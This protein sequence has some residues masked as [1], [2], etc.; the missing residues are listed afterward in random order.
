MSEG[1]EMSQRCCRTATL[2]LVLT[3]AA[4]LF[5]ACSGATTVTTT[6]GPGI[7]TLPS[8]TTGPVEVSTTVAPEAGLIDG[9]PAEY[10]AAYGQRPIVLL[11]Y[12]PGGVEDEQVLKTAQSLSNSFREYTFLL[13][14]YRIPAAYGDLAKDWGITYQPQT[15]LIDRHGQL[16][17]VWS[18]YVDTGTLNQS[19]INLGHE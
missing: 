17:K 11:F 18:G 1:D 9:L 19:L 12:V 8:P 7:T 5:V 14:D 13:Y 4:V 15:L 6:F 10:V 2:A 16:F 3:L